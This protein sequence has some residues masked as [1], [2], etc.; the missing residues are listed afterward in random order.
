M[1]KKRYA[2]LKESIKTMKIQRYKLIQD[3][4]GMGIDKIIKQNVRINDKIQK[5]Y[6]F[7]FI[8]VRNES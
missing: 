1:K 5:I 7:V 2:E 4:E 8:Y 3:C 6:F